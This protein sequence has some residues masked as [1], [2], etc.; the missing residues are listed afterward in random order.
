MNGYDE[1]ASSGSEDV[2]VAVDV[3]CSAIK[4]KIAISLV[5]SKKRYTH[6][7]TELPKPCVMEYR[8]ALL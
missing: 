5:Q 4:M 3:D 2:A 8:N 7:R 1:E 6:R